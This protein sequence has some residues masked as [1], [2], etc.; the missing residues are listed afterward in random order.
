ML[1]IHKHS[2][3]GESVEMRYNNRYEFENRDCGIG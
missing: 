1:I 3:F 2:G